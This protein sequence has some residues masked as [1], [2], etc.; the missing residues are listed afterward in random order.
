MAREGS[1][2]P[3]ATEQ[4]NKRI[5]SI[6]RQGSLSLGKSSC[7]PPREL[8]GK[9][10]ATDQKPDDD[11]NRWQNEWRRE[12]HVSREFTS[13][14]WWKPECGIVAKFPRQPVN[15]KHGK[16]ASQ[17]T[18]INQRGAEQADGRQNCEQIVL[19]RPNDDT[20]GALRTIEDNR[21]RSKA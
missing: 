11:K 20:L 17:D 5:S 9:P 19:Q 12:S 1:D 16:S 14:K 8:A 7:R 21:I 15:A 4:T 10:A 6:L 13:P 3:R 18:D 2:R